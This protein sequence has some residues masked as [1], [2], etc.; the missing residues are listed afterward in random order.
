MSGC[1]CKPDRAQPSIR[2]ITIVTL[3]SLR[4][5]FV[6][7][8]WPRLAWNAPLLAHHALIFRKSL[9]SDGEGQLNSALQ[10]VAALRG[11]F[12]IPTRR[13]KRID[14]IYAYIVPMIV[15]IGEDMLS[16]TARANSDRFD[17]N[18]SDAFVHLSK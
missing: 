3:L 1:E 8:D 5:F 14:E 16:R 18:R 6:S 4:S 17:S 11:D 9:T 13:K 12:D 10:R 15:L 2:E 7:L